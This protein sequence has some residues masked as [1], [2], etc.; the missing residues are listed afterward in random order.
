MWVSWGTAHVETNQ[1]VRKL[2]VKLVLKAVKK[3]S[4]V[5]RHPVNAKSP[6]KLCFNYFTIHSIK[7]RVI[8]LGVYIF[9]Q[10]NSVHAFNKH[11]PSAS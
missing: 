5:I 10:N 2:R 9:L 4:L 6:K 3:E 1:S 7:S 8:T 11:L